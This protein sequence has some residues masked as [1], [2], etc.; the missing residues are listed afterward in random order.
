MTAPKILIV[1]DDKVARKNLARIFSRQE[2]YT[3]QAGSGAEALE[4]ISAGGIDLVLTDLVMDEMS[5][6][7][8]LSGIKETDPEIEVIVVTAYASISTAIEATK[9]GAYHYLE[10][11]FRPEAVIHLARQAIEKKQ[12]RRK[13]TELESRLK[14]RPGEPGFIGESREIRE[15][16]KVARQVAKTGCNVLITGES[17]TG[18]ELA[19]SMIHYHSHRRDKK[20]LAVNCGAFTE[21]LLANEL[22]G[23]EKGAFTGASGFSPGLLEA[24]SGGT[25]FLDEIGDMPLSMQV[26]VMR[27]IEEQ[28]IIR[29][30]G[31]Q[32]IPVDVRIIAAT[33][34][35][36]KKALSAG[37]FRQDLYF[38]LNVISIYIPPLRE[39]KRDIPLMARFF[40]NRAGSRAGKKFT[41]FSKQAMKALM[42]YDYP[43][44]VRE[45]E[46]IVER[47]AAMAVD[48]EIQVKDLPPDISEMD[49]FSFS[50]TESD[51]KTLEEIKHEYIQW[52]LN[53]VGRNKTRAAEL[54]GIDRA[55]LWRHLRRH[56]IEE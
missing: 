42:D 47:A 35:D 50:R 20:F 3:A 29:V 32:E 49:V 12:L 28:K 31:N 7:E 41:G 36:L 39:R 16:I 56:E 17:G 26:K 24:A 52:V 34:K 19:A 13:V 18:K 4:H 33:N 54:L 21:E 48:E 25:L 2:F 43:G 27:A 14:D 15:V 30:G 45:L 37:I 5:G 53:R 55:S 6:L 9:K 22:F 8:L 51:I 11:P 1:D 10:K 40:L 46:N 38:R 44:N 23:H